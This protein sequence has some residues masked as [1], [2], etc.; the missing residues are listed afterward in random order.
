MTAH[1]PDE[2]NLGFSAYRLETPAALREA[3]DPEAA[4][5]AVVEI[6][7]LIGAGPMTS[8]PGLRAALID[9]LAPLVPEG[10]HPIELDDDQSH[11]WWQDMLTLLDQEKLAPPP[12]SSVSA[13]LDKYSSVLGSLAVGQNAGDLGA[14]VAEHEEFASTRRR[15]TAEILRGEPL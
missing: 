12:R 5:D 15:A 10:A 14:M 3:I 4:L 7:S 8:G 9:L 13:A 1:S 2:I 11:E 6:A